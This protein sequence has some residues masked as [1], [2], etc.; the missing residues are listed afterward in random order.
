M[1]CSIDVEHEDDLEVLVDK[2][3]ALYRDEI[4]Q[5]HP[6]IGNVIRY[7]ARTAPRTKFYGEKV[8]FQTIYWK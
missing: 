1:S 6:V 4:L 3:A 5:N 7:L 8:P 2:L